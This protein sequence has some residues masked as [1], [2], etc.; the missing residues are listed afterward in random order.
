MSHSQI[1]VRPDG[2]W[3]RKRTDNGDTHTAC[4]EP[5]GGAFFTRD[6]QLDDQMCEACFTPHERDTGRW[7]KIERD[8][9]LESDPGL[10]FDPDEEP[11]D[12]NGDSST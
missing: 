1:R 2:A 4:G 8:L 12:P 9:A 5:I 3:H 10:Y 6:W 7:K 11:T